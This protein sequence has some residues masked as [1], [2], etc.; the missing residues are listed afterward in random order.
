MSV[1]LLVVKNK[2]FFNDPE[3]VFIEEE[4]TCMPL[5]MFVRFRV[6]ENMFPEALFVAAALVL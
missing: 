2:I 6:V 5:R 4:Q 3:K 1:Q